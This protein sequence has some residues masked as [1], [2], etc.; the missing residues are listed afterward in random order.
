[1]IAE[2]SDT[3]PYGCKEVRMLWIEDSKLENVNAL[4]CIGLVFRLRVLI[5]MKRWPSRYLNH[6]RWALLSCPVLSC[7]VLS[8]PLPSLPSCPVPFPPFS[9]PVF[10]LHRPGPVPSSFLLAL[11]HLSPSP[12][13]Y[14]LQMIFKLLENGDCQS[15]VLAD[16]YRWNPIHASEFRFCCFVCVFSYQLFF[17]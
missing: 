14:L 5:F 8:C 2:D 11:C 16:V 3:I 13:L 15:I 6:A 7:P 9:S 1:M 12:L 10:S 4:T 17:E